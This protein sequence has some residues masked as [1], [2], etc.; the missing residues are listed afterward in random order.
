MAL[1]RNPGLIAQAL[2]FAQ[3]QRGVP[4]TWGGTTRAGGFDCS[5]LI[6]AAYRAAGYSGIGRTTYDQIKQ[7]VAIN[8]AQMHPGDIV[9]TENGAHE[10]MYIGNGYI[11]SSPHTGASVHTIPLNQF[12]SV[13]AVRRLVGGGG[14][15]LPP[16]GGASPGPAGLPIPHYGNQGASTAINHAVM[17]VSLPAISIKPPTLNLPTAQG[18]LAS[19]YPTPLATKAAQSSLLMPPPVVSAGGRTNDQLT[20][21]LGTLR[22]KLLG[23]T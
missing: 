21:D 12:G 19:T 7:G 1:A 20:G 16:A 5:G 10:G 11:V 23:I 22:Q 8:P 15:L 14:G 3:R 13:Y 17:R 6:Y 18:A 4:Y 9:F 2:A